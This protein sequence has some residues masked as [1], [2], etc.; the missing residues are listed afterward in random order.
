M[1]P[2]LKWQLW[3]AGIR[4]NR[5]AK[6]LG[7]DETILSKIVNGSREPNA[8]LRERIASVLQR[9]PEWLFQPADA[10][11]RSDQ[12]SDQPAQQKKAGNGGA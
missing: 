7:M 12:S 5:L 11:V 8:Q 6:I 4:Q 9:D 1:Y 2:N 10:P 3:V